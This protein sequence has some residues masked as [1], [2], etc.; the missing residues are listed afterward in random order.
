MNIVLTR[1]DSRLI[2]GQVVQGWLPSLKVQEV[3][4]VSST[5]F[6]SNLMCKM[7]RMSLPKAYGLQV[8]CAHDAASYLKSS[9]EGKILLLVEDFDSL[10]KLLEDGVKLN[11][12]TIGNTRYEEGKKQYSQGVFLSE[13]EISVIKQKAQAFSVN[14][15]IQTLPTS[16]S[17]RLF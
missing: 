4:V 9:K 5:A 1:I 2:H 10:F 16:L 12:I 13:E 7:M 17:T 15:V 11:E 6:E 3:V 14:F 8:L